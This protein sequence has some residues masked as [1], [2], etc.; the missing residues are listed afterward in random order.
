[1]KPTASTKLV[2]LH[3]KA[4]RLRAEADA[5]PVDAV[6]PRLRLT[7]QY[8]AVIDLIRVLQGKNPCV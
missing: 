4:R 5:L 2:R 1:M 3:A 7:D 6:M 8:L